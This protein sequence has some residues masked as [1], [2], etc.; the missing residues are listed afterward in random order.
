MTRGWNE[1]DL[2]PLCPVCGNQVFPE[3]MTLG[4]TLVVMHPECKDEE[5]EDEAS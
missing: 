4:E 5:E 3:N 2:A 1:G